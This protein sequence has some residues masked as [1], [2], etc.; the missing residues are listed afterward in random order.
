[1]PL[2]APQTERIADL[3]WLIHELRQLS[4]VRD[5]VPFDEKPGPLPSVTDMLREWYDECRDV[6]TPILFDAPSVMGAAESLDD[7][8]LASITL[9]T[10]W[11]NRLNAESYDW[12]RIVVEEQ[13]RPYSASEILELVVRQERGLFKE[14]LER[15]HTIQKPVP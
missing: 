13:G 1:M 6:L 3:D 10:D 15:F 12:S 7:V 11:L 14:I 4:A 9:R 5:V 8:L 2:N